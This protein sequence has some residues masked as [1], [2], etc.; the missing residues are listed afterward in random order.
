MLSLI[1]GS[2]LYVHFSDHLLICSFNKP[3][4]HVCCVP[5]LGVGIKKKNLI[6]LACCLQG[7]PVEVNLCK[8]V[9]KFT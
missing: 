1:Y 7:V 4:L 5:G 8:Q 2:H 9:V 6:K 3:L